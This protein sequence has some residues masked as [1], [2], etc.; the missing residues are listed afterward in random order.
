MIKSKNFSS[1]ILGI[2]L[3]STLIIGFIIIVFPLYITLVTSMKTAAESSQNFF[4]LPTHI[5]LDNF[6]RVLEKSDFFIYTRNSIIITVISLSGEILLV[7]AFAYAVSRNKNK[8]FFKIIYY[9][10]II[11]LFIP[12]QVVM[13]PTVKLLSKISLLNMT[14]VI[15]LYLT[16]TLKKGVFLVVGYLDNISIDLEHSAYI[17]G[18]SRF[19]VYRLIIFPLLTP[20]IATLLIVDGLWIWNDFLMPLLIL[21]Q[22]SH[23]WTLPLFQAQFKNQFSFDYNLAFASF[24]LSML[25]II[26]FYAFM[27][28]KIMGGIINGAIKG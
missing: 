12:F 2:L 17:D 19:Q 26:I 25:P 23:S 5:Y 1:L 18:C 13:L 15:L 14:G 16:Y 3:Y 7:P 28:K 8:P 4:S 27:Q 20:I 11:G 6:K 24:L 22:D 9:M 21:N 10:T